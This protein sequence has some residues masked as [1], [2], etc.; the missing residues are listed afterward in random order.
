MAAGILKGIEDRAPALGQFVE[1]CVDEPGKLTLDVS[2]RWR[3]ARADS[4]I[5]CTAQ[6]C[7]SADRPRSASGAKPSKAS[8]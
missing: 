8:S 2:P 4:S 3:E 6:R 1:R 7:R 5:C